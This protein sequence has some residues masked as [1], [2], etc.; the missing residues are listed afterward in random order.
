[1]FYGAVR[2]VSCVKAG[3]INLK[4][5]LTLIQVNRQ[6]ALDRRCLFYYSRS[7]C[8]RSALMKP[9]CYDGGMAQKTRSVFFRVGIGLLAV[10]LMLGACIQGR[11]GLGPLGTRLP[12]L[13]PID[14]G[15]PLEKDLTNKLIA[16]NGYQS[17]QTLQVAPGVL[18]RQYE[19][20]TKRDPRQTLRALVV[21]PRAFR[22]LQ[23]MFSDQTHQ[24]LSTETVLARP[25]V[26]VLM[27]WCFFGRIPAGDVIGLRC[28][29][30][31]RKC[32]P[33][34]Y[35]LARQRTGKAIDQ[36]YLFAIK[37][38]G[39]TRVFR[40]GLDKSSA[41]HYRLA[42][43]G[44]LLLFDQQTA[45]EL[46]KAVGQK[47]YISLYSSPRYNHGDLVSKG[48]AGYPWRN[49]PRSAAALLPDGSLV[50]INLGEG[51]Y[52]FQGGA[53]PSRLAVLLKQLGARKAIM[54]D[55]GG[56]PQ[57]VIKSRL[58]QTLVRS[59]PEATKQS[60]YLYN[61]AFLTLKR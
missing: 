22:R 29:G 16:P 41:Q 5:V 34:M 18:F 50:L 26:Q 47:N 58:G 60:N 31:G 55:G 56:A 11:D 20:G 36:R 37:H 45:P 9:L 27:S 40:G 19:N 25:E 17:V 13:A 48:Q 28:S 14:T 59:R 54:F 46:Y 53:S 32:Q 52:R 43:G 30:S 23:V 33:G 35:H 2:P 7:Q 57:M 10:Q 15:V 44:G 49:A 61:Y 1:M 38:D 4:I 12:Q 51:Q 3:K 42:M 6:S 21:H 24:P 8:F 39:N